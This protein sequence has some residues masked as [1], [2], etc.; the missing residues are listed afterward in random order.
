[1]SGF[2]LSNLQV[3]KILYLAHMTYAGVLDG[4]ALIGDE[5]FEAWAY[6]P[7]LPHV[8]RYLRSFGG[9]RVPNVFRRIDAPVNAATELRI[10]DDAVRT[11]A[12]MEPWRLVTLLHRTDGA[13]FKNYQTGRNRAIPMADILAEYR[14]RIRTPSAEGNAAAQPA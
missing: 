2:S 5:V 4:A 9:D 3:Q 7:V 6:G 13:W 11:F 8:Y 14:A 12:P 1:M 10:L